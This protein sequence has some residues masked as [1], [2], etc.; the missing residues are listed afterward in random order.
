MKTYLKVQIEI[1]TNLKKNLEKLYNLFEDPYK[2]LKIRVGLDKKVKPNYYVDFVITL[3]LLETTVDVL[4][5][6][7]NLPKR[8]KE[9]VLIDFDCACNNIYQELEA[10]LRKKHKNLWYYYNDLLIDIEQDLSKLKYYL[11]INDITNFL[12]TNDL[13]TLDCFIETIL[14]EFLYTPY[15]AQEI[16]DILLHNKES[17]H[18]MYW[19]V[20]EADPD[21]PIK[22]FKKINYIKCVSLDSESISFEISFDSDNTSYE[23]ATL[24]KKLIDD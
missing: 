7:D 5:Y 21:N 17:K 18:D 1:I 4:R 2:H 14:A 9:L 10:I 13:I 15:D 16:V 23:V 22:D 8:F 11:D 24:Y 12:E 3:D 6:K 20:N 19:D